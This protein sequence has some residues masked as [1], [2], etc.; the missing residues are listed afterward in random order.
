MTWCISGVNNMVPRQVTNL[1]CSCGGLCRGECR[2]AN[3]NRK[4]GSMCP[5]AYQKFDMKKFE[6]VIKKQRISKRQ[7][8]L[9]RG[10]R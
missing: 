5:S 2:D 6:P 9:N 3:L 4:D 1:F 7:Q 8:K 10:K